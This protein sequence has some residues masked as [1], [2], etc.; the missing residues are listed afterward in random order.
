MFY[1]TAAN[2]ALLMGQGSSVD[3]GAVEPQASITFNSSTLSGTYFLG[4]LGVTSQSQQTEIDSATLANGV[5][6]AI[7]DTN[8]T[9]YQGI[10]NIGSIS[11]TVNADGTVTSTENGVPIVKMIIINNTRFVM[12]NNITDVYPYL[13]I[14]QQ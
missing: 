9:T 4:G 6:T 10:D 8:S 13:V 1:L 3:F 11:I 2:S 7:N 5:G 14:G 12:V